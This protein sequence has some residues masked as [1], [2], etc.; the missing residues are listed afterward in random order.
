MP[1]RYGRN[2]SESWRRRATRGSRQCAR[3]CERRPIRGFEVD[4]ACRRVIE[5]A[6][7][8]E[9]FVHRTGHNIGENTHGNG[10]HMDNLETREERRVHGA[11]S[12]L[13]SR[14]STSRSL[15][16]GAKSMCFVDSAARPRDRRR[17]AKSGIA[18]S[19]GILK[20]RQAAVIA[21][22]PS[23]EK[24]WPQRARHYRAAQSRSSCCAVGANSL[25]T[26]VAPRLLGKVGIE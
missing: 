2:I 24:T 5:E 6:G 15:A 12:S 22:P 19:G 17:T 23:V 9:Y 13:S 25:C 4:D 18:D 7:Y 3:L 11:R 8:G 26:E 1:E 16:C 21:V 14:G 20:A 10:A